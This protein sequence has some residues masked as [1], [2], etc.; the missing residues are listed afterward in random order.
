MPGR[1]E[2]L[3]RGRLA[4]ALAYLEQ[5]PYENVFVYANFR[6]QREE[7]TAGIWC[8]PDGTIGGCCWIGPQLV[9]AFDARAEPEA[10]AAIARA[11]RGQRN[12]RML[13][14]PRA[15]V[16][17]VW[18][19]LA[20]GRHD[21]ALVRERQ[22]LYALE[23]QHFDD[24][25]AGARDAV[26]R[27]TLAELDEIAA[28]SAAMIGGEIDAAPRTDAAFRERTARII[29]GD[30]WWRYRIDGRLVF[31][32]H[33]GARSPSTVQIQGVWTPP[34]LRGRGYATRGLAAICARLLALHPTV[35]LYVNEFNT[36]AIAIYARLGFRV[37][38]E[39]QTI[40]LR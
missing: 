8:A 2:P 25:L 11:A 27:A 9:P 18:R 30:S 16:R 23:P 37:V 31:M 38:G 36:R 14:G 22:P 26:G 24:S 10:A 33:L 7:G 4:A 19:E 35:S 17:A 15:A 1:L 3:S 32:C 20:V 12:L 39:F 5:R 28:H 13:V 40:L 29:A 6:A 34:E 21:I